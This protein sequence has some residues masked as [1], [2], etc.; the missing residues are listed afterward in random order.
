MRVSSRGRYV[1]LISRPRHRDKY[2][3]SSLSHLVYCARAHYFGD[4]RALISRARARAYSSTIFNPRRKRKR[5]PV[6][7]IFRRH[8]SKRNCIRARIPIDCYIFDYA[9]IRET[10]GSEGN[11]ATSQRGNLRDIRNDVNRGESKRLPRKRQPAPRIQSRRAEFAR[12]IC[13][14]ERNCY[15]RNYASDAF[16]LSFSETGVASRGSQSNRSNG[17]MLH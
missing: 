3:I 17:Q 4:Y 2:F 10:A 15:R 6:S 8:S 7:E 13:E 1:D 14:S 5:I 12:P 11:D 16:S 9:C